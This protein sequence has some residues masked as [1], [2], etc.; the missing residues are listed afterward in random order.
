MGLTETRRLRIIRWLRN[1]SRGSRDLCLVAVGLLAMA[2][3]PPSLYGVAV[4]GPLSCIWASMLLFGALSSFLGVLIR[5]DLAEIWG[6]VW[7][8]VAFALW[9]YAAVAQ[10]DANELSWMLAFVFW[11]GSAGQLFRVATVLA[12]T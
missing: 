5:N 2:T 7:V 6:C 9:G 1:G 12:R 3:T 10:P 11:A 8:G 4:E